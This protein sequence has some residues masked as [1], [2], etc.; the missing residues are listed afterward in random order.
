MAHEPMRVRYVVGEADVTA[1]HY[2]GAGFTDEIYDLDGADPHTAIAYCDM[3]DDAAALA[4]RLNAYEAEI[5]RLRTIIRMARERLYD[6]H[7]RDQATVAQVIR[8]VGAI[9]RRAD[10]ARDDAE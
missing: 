10:A 1:I 7:G 2:A 8:A 6:A 9:L 3:P 5:A 4:A